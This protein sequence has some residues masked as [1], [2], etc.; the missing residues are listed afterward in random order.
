M[1]DELHYGD[2]LLLVGALS[3]ETPLGRVVLIRRENDRKRLSKFTKSE[4]HIRNEWQ[5][6]RAN[7]TAERDR[8]HPED[9]AAMFE[10]M[11]AGMFGKIV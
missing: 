9:Y 1:Q 6:F 11:F 8:K 10:K 5:R 7:Q 2:W 3:D 4:H